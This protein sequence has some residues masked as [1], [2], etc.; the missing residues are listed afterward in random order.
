MKQAGE[1]IEKARARGLD[2]AADMYLYTAGGTSLT[3]VVP[4]VGGG[5]RTRQS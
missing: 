4:V 3:A 2:V 5:W 1:T